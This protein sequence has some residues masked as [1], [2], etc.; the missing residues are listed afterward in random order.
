MTVTQKANSA[1]TKKEDNQIPNKVGMTK[2]TNRPIPGGRLHPREMG[3]DGREGRV[4]ASAAVCRGAA[5]CERLG[6]AACGNHG[7]E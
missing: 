6:Q 2:M 4:G 5:A 3:G 7:I 1:R